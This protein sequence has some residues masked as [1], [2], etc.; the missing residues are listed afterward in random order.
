MRRVGRWIGLVLSLALVVFL[1]HK[2]QNLGEV[3]QALAS[4][5]YRW[6]VAAAALYLCS[7]V[8]RGLRWQR[9]LK[10]ART[11]RLAALCEV[12]AIGFMANN[13]LPLRLGEFVRAYVLG[14]KERISATTAFATIVVE[15]ACDGLTLVLALAIVSSF[16]PFPLWVK[17]LGLVAAVL[18]L[19]IVAFLVLLA[20]RRTWAERIAG[21]ALRPLPPILRTRL[22]GA[23]DEVDRGLHLLRSPWDA[24]AVLGLSVLIW[25]IEFA[26]YTRVLAAFSAP[27][28]HELG[29]PVPLHTVLLLLVVLNF[30]IMIPSAPGY[31]GPFQ[32][33]VIAVLA[34]VA[35]LTNAVAFS[36]SWVLW[37]T[38]VLPIVVIGLVLLSFEQISLAKLTVAARSGNM[39][40]IGPPA[41]P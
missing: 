1:L 19:G 21:V 24:L 32:A 15:R 22:L 10:G 38:L 28:F 39:E 11:I 27:I 33:A 16:Y 12:L 17:R 3:K 9:L 30:G 5:D 7:F 37:G 31:I 13:A 2:V 4:A 18:F 8:P 36:I 41:G 14:R 29:H 40:R 34:G 6:V 23:L 20:Y 25:S 26:V 35:G